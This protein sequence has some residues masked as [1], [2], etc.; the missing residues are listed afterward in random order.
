M[1]WSKQQLLGLNQRDFKVTI[2]VTEVASGNGHIV[3]P[4]FEPAC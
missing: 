3:L 1:C 2:G 4:T